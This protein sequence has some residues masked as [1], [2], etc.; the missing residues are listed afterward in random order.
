MRDAGGGPV[1]GEM[2]ATEL[3]VE[4]AGWTGAVL[5]LLAYL[6]LSMG[7]LSGQSAG[8]SGSRAGVRALPGS[9][10]GL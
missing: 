2:S 10:P 4:A 3:L 1:I 6:L 9:A 5:I 8:P 7:R